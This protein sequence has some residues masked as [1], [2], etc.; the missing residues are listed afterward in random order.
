[1]KD[2]SKEHTFRAGTWGAIVGG[3]VGFALGLLLAPEE[4]RRL[5]R[6][7]AYQLDHISEQVADLIEIYDTELTDAQLSAFV[8]SAHYLI[9]ANLLN[10]GLD[11]NILTEIHK[12]L[13]AHFASLR[14][15]RVQQERVAE[16]GKTYQGKTDMYLESTSYGQM[17]VALD[18]SGTLANLGE[19]P[20][21]FLTFTT[22]KHGSD[23]RP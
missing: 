15:Q 16:I 2:R 4:G 17:A 10:K 13:A 8:N 19:Q 11:E 23:L 9:Q 22:P 14:D 21:T 18:T 3:A 5:R 20:A 1:M 7:L 6:K 12:Y